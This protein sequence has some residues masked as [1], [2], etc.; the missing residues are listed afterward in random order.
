MSAASPMSTSLILNFASLEQILMSQAEAKS[1]PAP[2]QYP[3]I[4]A[5]TGTLTFS[6][7]LTEFCKGTTVELIS[8]AARAG[9]LTSFAI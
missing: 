8:K 6:R 7:L 3:C 2:M 5:M 4:A 1:T 9:S